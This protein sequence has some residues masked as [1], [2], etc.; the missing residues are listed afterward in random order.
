MIKGTTSAAFVKKTIGSMPSKFET[1]VYMH[2]D[3]K[4]KGFGSNSE[5]FNEFGVGG[6]SRPET[7]SEEPG[8]GSYLLENS[9]SSMMKRSESF[10]KKGYGNGFISKADRFVKRNDYV[11]K[12]FMPGPGS[13]TASTHED[14][15][16]GTSMQSK[17]TD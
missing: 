17:F 14:S 10:S 6:L 8:P 13:Y 11:Q 2:A 15:L 9:I 7:A 12:W 1:I 4:K 16:I 5:R 3:S